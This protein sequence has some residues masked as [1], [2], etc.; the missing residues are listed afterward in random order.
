MSEEVDYRF[1]VEIHTAEGRQKIPESVKKTL[2]DAGMAD[3]RGK[4]RIKG[5]SPK[6]MRRMKQEYVECPVLEEQTH[7][8]KCFLCPNFQSRVKGMV[9]CMGKPLPDGKAH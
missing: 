6:M 1:E 9:L 8:V 3:D 2:H 5:V 4:L 7:F